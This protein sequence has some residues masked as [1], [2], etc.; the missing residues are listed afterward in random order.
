MSNLIKQQYCRQLTP[1]HI[2]PHPRLSL[3]CFL[4]CTLSVCLPVPELLGSKS[5]D[6][7]GN[8]NMSLYLTGGFSGDHGNDL[9]YRRVDREGHEMTFDLDTGA[10]RRSQSH[11]RMAKLMPAAL[12]ESRF[13]Q[14]PRRHGV[15]LLAQTDHEVH[16]EN[17][18]VSARH[19][20]TVVSLPSTSFY[21]DYFLF[22]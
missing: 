21:F 9:I 22:F 3:L 1:S 5:A 4:F 16:I 6:D 11:A 19:I 17:A 20:V 10:W 2:L 8:D 18:P 7:F 14:A 13:R 12:M 15:S